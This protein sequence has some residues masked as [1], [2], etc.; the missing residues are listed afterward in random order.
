MSCNC[1][2]HCAF[3]RTAA[4]DGGGDVVDDSE[5]VVLEQVLMVAVQ[6]EKSELA[7]DQLVGVVDLSELVV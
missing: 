7:V 4:G 5:L 2:L 6:V 1:S 3:K